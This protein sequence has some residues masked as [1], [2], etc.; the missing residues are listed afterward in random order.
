[1]AVA[2]GGDGTNPW[3]Y[4]G[5]V[6]TTNNASYQDTYSPKVSDKTFEISGYQEGFGTIVASNTVTFSSGQS[7]KVE[8]AYRLDEGANFLK[9]DTL[10]TNT[11]GVDLTNVRLW[12][13]TRDDFVAESDGNYKFKGNLS[14][15]FELIA[16]QNQQAKAIKISESNDGITGAAILFY[17]TSAGA[18]TVVDSCCY[19]S[20][21][22][23]K[24]PRSSTIETY[25]DGSYALY[26]RLNDLTPAASGGMTWYYAAAPVSQINNVVSSVAQSAGVAAPVSQPST[27]P[28]SEPQQAAIQ[29]VQS[30][31]AQQQQQQPGAT[32]STTPQPFNFSTAAQSGSSQATGQAIGSLDVV[33]LQLPTSG[34]SQLGGGQSSE[35]TQGGNNTQGS[36]DGTGGDIWNA[37][38]GQPSQPGLLNV[39]VAGSGVQM[40]NG[41]TD[42][43]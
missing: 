4:N 8:N 33:Q 11:S 39:Y 23:N 19:F 12:V 14:N 1:M 5:E 13:G 9:T 17:S 10:V 38:S 24:N 42:E 20:N 26:M 43:E 41:I 35:T 27:T 32:Q 31:V 15:G 37:I 28:V 6:L 30:Q 40:P 2:S 18:D 29:T 22:T 3:N 34:N 36:G 7:I 25:G 16:D 21:V